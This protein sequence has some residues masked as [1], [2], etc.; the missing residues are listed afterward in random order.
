ME[1]LIDTLSGPPRTKAECEEF[2]CNYF[3]RKNPSIYTYL[4][5]EQH[6][7]VNRFLQSDKSKRDMDLKLLIKRIRAEVAEYVRFHVFRRYKMTG[8]WRPHISHH[9]TGHLKKL[10]KLMWTTRQVTLTPESIM[11]SRS[12]TKGH[13]IPKMVPLRKIVSVKQHEKDRSKLNI[14]LSDS[15]EVLQFD[16]QSESEAISWILSINH[17]RM[18]GRFDDST[19]SSSIDTSFSSQICVEVLRNDLGF[20]PSPCTSKRGTYHF[21]TVVSDIK[22][23]VLKDK[24]VRD[25]DVITAVND[26]QAHGS[27]FDVVVEKLS[28]SSPP[29]PTTT[30]TSNGEKTCDDEN[31]DDKN[32]KVI[33]TFRRRAS[34]SQVDVTMTAADRRA[35]N[36]ASTMVNSQ[37]R[38]AS[39][40]LSSILSLT[41]RLSHIIAEDSVTDK[42]NKDKEEK[43]YFYARGQGRRQ[44]VWTLRQMILSEDGETL[45]L[46][47]PQIKSDV[48][49]KELDRMDREHEF[50]NNFVHKRVL[51]VKEHLLKEDGSISISEHVGRPP[52]LSHEDLNS[53]FRFWWDLVQIS[54]GRGMSIETFR[55][56]TFDGDMDIKT[57]DEVFKEITSNSLDL[58]FSV[59]KSFRSGGRGLDKKRQ[60]FLPSINMTFQQWSS[61][62][63]PCARSFAW[64]F[65]K[66]LDEDNN[67]KKRPSD[68]KSRGRKVS[69]ILLRELRKITQK[70][71]DSVISTKDLKVRFNKDGKLGLQYDDNLK[72]FVVNDW[73]KRFGFRPGQ[74]ILT[75][76]N[77]NVKTQQ[78][79]RDALRSCVDR[80]KEFLVQV[81]TVAE[82]RRSYDEIGGSKKNSSTDEEVE[83]S[84]FS[85]KSVKLAQQVV[86][87]FVRLGVEDSSSISKWYVCDVFFSLSLPFSSLIYPL[88]SLINP[89]THTQVCQKTTYSVYR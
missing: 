52:S 22:N 19:S 7:T 11:Y 64:T 9:K 79:I 16:A 62:L 29:P 78:D 85:E 47:T 31:D 55:Y 74:K 73:A 13:T 53:W 69:N 40:E 46:K 21:S 17:A 82:R 42:E 80:S 36:R 49:K 61:W 20:R 88:D 81:K 5:D 67:K 68:E 75:F 87:F 72:I 66:K 32:N 6:E 25:G 57:S 28:T 83:D 65:K 27:S 86:K 37:R 15:E 38:W 60:I 50:V 12:S 45:R 56:L 51:K 44:N 39:Q 48:I 23:K 33:V 34:R 63:R 1:F 30:T 24:G 59:D 84:H 18:A 76:M 2:L 77:R 14:S 41:S 35:M 10:G 26:W 8:L 3:K 4:S 58:L 71:R 54:D 43:V 70:Q 89:L